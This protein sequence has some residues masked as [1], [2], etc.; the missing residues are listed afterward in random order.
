MKLHV[1]VRRTW[2]HL[3]SKFERALSSG[4]FCSQIPKSKWHQYFGT[5]SRSA[6]SGLRKESRSTC[7]FGRFA[8][9]K[10]PQFF[11]VAPQEDERTDNDSKIANF[12]LVALIQPPKV[13]WHQYCGTEGV[14][15][16]TLESLALGNV[17]D[18]GR[19]P[20]SMLSAGS[21]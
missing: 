10:V 14:S 15:V 1:L 8:W 19:N 18:R 7:R 12:R 16:L 17:R 4:A 13:K 2:G 3:S 21:H 11:C 6:C 5:K 20:S 9:S